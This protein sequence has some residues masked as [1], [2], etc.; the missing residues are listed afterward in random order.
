MADVRQYAILRERQETY[1]KVFEKM[2]AKQSR[3]LATMER[4]QKLM[5]GALEEVRDKLFQEVLVFE[6]RISAEEVELLETSEEMK[7]L[8]M[9]RRRT[10]AEE[11]RDSDNAQADVGCDLGELGV[12]VGQGVSLGSQSSTSCVGGSQKKRKAVVRKDW[13]CKN[14]KGI[15]LDGMSPGSCATGRAGSEASSSTTS[16]RHCWKTTESH[17]R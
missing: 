7:D 17:I 4:K 10:E 9:G 15:R 14:G 11:W 2:N 12:G 13:K 5:S 6:D 16:W 8:M 1:C 3:L